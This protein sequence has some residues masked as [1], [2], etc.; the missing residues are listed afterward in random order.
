MFKINFKSHN[1]KSTLD[2]VA[3]I[4]FHETSVPFCHFTWKTISVGRREQVG[5]THS[6]SSRVTLEFQWRFRT[7][8]ISG[9]SSF[10]CLWNP[11][12][13]SICSLRLW[14]GRPPP[15]HHSHNPFTPPTPVSWEDVFFL[16]SGYYF[17]V[18]V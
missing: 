5:E 7:R 3:V 10:G 17:R 16:T 1:P 18:I 12:Q 4:N 2:A 14:I 8:P 6:K 15:P 9:V 11:A 13:S